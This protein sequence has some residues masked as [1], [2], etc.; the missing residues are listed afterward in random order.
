MSKTMILLSE[1][2]WNNKMKNISPELKKLV[3]KTIKEIDNNFNAI[4]EPWSKWYGFYVRKPLSIQNRF[5]VIRITS[6]TA[7][8]CFRITPENFSYEDPSFK[9][10]SGYFFGKKPEM[11]VN[12]KLENIPKLIKFLEYS[13]KITQSNCITNN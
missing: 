1:N 6:K 3:K 13:Y 11:T 5:A 9:M 4:S 12:I 10:V 7:T 8:L 2:S